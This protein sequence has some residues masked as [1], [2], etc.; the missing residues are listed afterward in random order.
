MFA[1]RPYAE[2]HGCPRR[3]PPHNQPA[4]S[5]T[6][7]ATR[8]QTIPSPCRGNRNRRGSSL[9]QTLR[10]RQSRGGGSRRSSARHMCCRAS[11]TPPRLQ[12]PCRT[13]SSSRQPKCAKPYAFRKG[14]REGGQAEG[15]GSN[16]GRRRSSSCP[17]RRSSSSP[18][19]STSCPSRPASARSKGN[20]RVCTVA[21]RAAPGSQRQERSSGAARGG[22]SPRP[23]ARLPR[24]VAHAFRTVRKRCRA[25]TSASRAGQ[26]H[27]A[28]RWRVAAPAG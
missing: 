26:W 12:Q 1:A 5:P 28:Q 10:Q 23:A 17:P 20:R 9:L 6:R 19:Y 18:R 8:R 25:R 7:P 13:A 4:V 2:R 24:A 16:A 3:F 11:A 21:R 15:A 22:R 27:E 14:Q